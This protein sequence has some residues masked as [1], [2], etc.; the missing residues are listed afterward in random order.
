MLNQQHEQVIPKIEPS[1][2]REEVPEWGGFEDLLNEKH[3]LEM[4][5]H[6]QTGEYNQNNMYQEENFA[7]DPIDFDCKCIEDRL[8]GC[9]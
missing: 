8:F 1:Q 4:S 7:D 5:G 9:G 3:H 6:Y 2:Q